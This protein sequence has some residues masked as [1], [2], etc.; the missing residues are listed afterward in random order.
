MLQSVGCVL[1]VRDA[2]DQRI[3]TEVQNRTGAIIDVQGGFPHGTPI[4]T[5]QVAWPV[6]TCGP[7]PADSDHDG[8][9]DAYELANG[10]NPNNAADRQG[11]A[12]NG[13][14]NLENYL[15]GLVTV[16]TATRPT[17]AVIEPLHLFPNPA[18]EQLTV[19]H[20]RAT[21]AARL[22]VYNFVGQRVASF[23]P[24]LGGASTPVSLSNL[25]K[26]N[27]LVVYTDANVS[28]TAKCARE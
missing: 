12:A 11:I 20:P 10:L 18:T 22:T 13:Y 23:A 8:M 3:I 19:E 14:T 25:A 5:S 6:L 16:A 1:P 24:A 17:G 27:Y 7:A 4:S 15:N 26:G 9:T 28:M 21:A 2:V